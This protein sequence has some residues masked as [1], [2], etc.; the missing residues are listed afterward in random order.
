MNST[1]LE[2][3]LDLP[4]SSNEDYRDYNVKEPK[5]KS[6][7]PKIVITLLVIAF[8]CNLGLTGWLYKERTDLINGRG[9]LLESLSIAQQKGNIASEKLETQ[10]GG[11][12][13]KCLT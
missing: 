12:S 7:L 6:S 5:R 4:K 8:I 1:V 13:I 2:Y 10:K 11:F 3:E 9:T